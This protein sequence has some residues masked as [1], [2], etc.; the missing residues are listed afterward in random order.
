[1]KRD[2]RD[3][4]K[5][6]RGNKERKGGLESCYPPKMRGAVRREDI[7]DQ[8]QE[9]SCVECLDRGK[10]PVDNKCAAPDRLLLH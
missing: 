1:M 5:K 9:N 4:E 3:K 10:V 2:R 6:E 7:Y 8:R